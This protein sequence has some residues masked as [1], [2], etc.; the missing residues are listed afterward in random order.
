MYRRRSMG[1]AL[2]R[3]ALSQGI[4]RRDDVSIV[5]RRPEHRDELVDELGRYRFCRI[6]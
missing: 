2:L 1:G 6:T 5:V 3:G 4:L